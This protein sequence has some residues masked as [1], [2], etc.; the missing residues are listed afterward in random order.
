[1]TYTRVFLIACIILF[2]PHFV[3][4]H[5]PVIVEQTSLHDIEIVT[6]P[7]RSQAFYGTLDDFPHTYEIRVKEPFLLRAE[8]LIPDTDSAKE[9]VSGI[10]IRETGRQGKVEEVTRMLAKDA[11]WES[12]YEFWGGDR[13]RR[14]GLYEAEVTPGVYRIEVSTPDNDAS[15]VLVIG[16]EE[17]W[18]DVG[19]FEMIGRIAD[20]K[21]FFGKP[22]VMVVQSP[23]IFIPLL[24]IIGVC[25]I[26]Y[27]WRKRR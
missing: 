4:A 27:I 6:D 16:T 14:G 11:T 7:V 21:A 15:Y 8:V 5:V 12:F 24:G 9:L 25:V 13:Y 10:V 18:G 3:R 19:Y 22:T 20:V 1:M 17:E 26:L 2:T 23:L